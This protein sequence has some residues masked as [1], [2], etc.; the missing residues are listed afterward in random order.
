MPGIRPV[1]FW[2]RRVGSVRLTKMR[3]RQFISEWRYSLILG[4]VAGAA[5]AY[6][7]FFLVEVTIAVSHKNVSL[8]FIRGIILFSVFDLDIK[9]PISVSQVPLHQLSWPAF[10]PSWGWVFN[11]Y[12]DEGCCM[13]GINI[14]YILFIII[15]ALLYIKSKRPPPPG[16]QL[17][18]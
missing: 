14:L 9:G 18:D 13:F 2:R 17:L 11:I 12:M 3:L 4:C 10:Q 1:L 7:E 8:S 15:I 5:W 16:F 6:S